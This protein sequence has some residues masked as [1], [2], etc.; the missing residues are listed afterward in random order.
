MRHGIGSTK[1]GVLLATAGTACAL[2][3]PG[4]ASA[5]LLS[6]GS[7]SDC[8]V[9]TSKAFAAW[10]DTANYRI[11][12]GGS[13]ESGAAWTLSG[14]AKVVAGNEPFNV[15]PG[16]HSLSLTN[17]ATAVSPK[18]CFTFG[19]WHMRFLVRNTGNTAGKLKVDVLVPTLVGLVSVLDGGYVQADGS[20][21]PSPNVSAL[22]TN[23][24]GLLGLTKA[25]SFR[26][27]ATGTGA[28]FQVDD[29][30][31]DPFRCR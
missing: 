29:V 15:V 5:G 16:T 23:V 21:D 10:G 14:G 17:G 7:A 27:R 30:F 12:P 9:P 6:T 28:S 31:L 2:I 24:G 22:L 13:F 4:A 25:V 26:L 19:D 3:A 20:W 18:T 1:L 11:V 8:D